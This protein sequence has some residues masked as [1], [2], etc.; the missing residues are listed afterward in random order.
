VDEFASAAI[1]EREWLHPLSATIA[2]SQP[3]AGGGLT[4]TNPGSVVSEVQSVCAT[5]V[6]SAQAAS[7]IPVLT[8][9]GISGVTIGVFPSPY[10]FAASKTTVVTWGVGLVVTGADDGARVTVPI[11]GYVLELGYQLVVS[12]DAEDAADQLSNVV[13]AAKQ[14]PVR[15]PIGN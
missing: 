4:Y 5:L 6:T 10:T 3:A 2:F 1:A 12:V 7:R 13:L 9:K 11:P 15:A 14:W 8:V